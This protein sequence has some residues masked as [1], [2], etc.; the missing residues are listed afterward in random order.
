M[1]DFRPLTKFT[2]FRGRVAL[3]AILKAL[4]VGRGDRVGMQAYTCIAVPEAVLAAGA[5][6]VFIDIESEGL[7]MDASACTAAMSSGIKAIIVQHTFGLPADVRA[8][9]AVAGRHGIPVIEDC[10]HS[11]E[12][13]IAGRNVGSFGIAGFYSFEW[14]KPLVAGVGGSAVT[15]DVELEAKLARDYAGYISPPHTLDFRIRA[16]YL[17]YRLF[18]RPSF[19]WGTRRILGNFSNTGLVDSNYHKTYGE[20]E[21]VEF[22]YRMIESA[23]SRLERALAEI[24]AGTAHSNKI[25]ADYRR[26][27]GNPLIGHI[28]VPPWA[29]PVYA[30]YP[31]R[32]PDKCRLL[33]AAEKCRVEIAGWYATPVHPLLQS[34]W[35][36]VGYVAG[37]CPNAE[38]AC[39]EVVSL[40]T[41]RRVTQADAD[42]AVDFLN[43]FHL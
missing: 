21:S 20:G 37:S 11:L 2:Y 3:Y 4:G 5:R 33:G 15:T 43:T 8:I 22:K 32:S 14:G 41:H 16:Q 13:Q 7:N 28:P 9:Q 6:P 12:T 10:C 30:R 19:Y 35:K 39:S 1:T 34:E 23:K 17:A 18:F 38:R 24:P 27:I 36:G 42:K 29:S 31:L 40:P 25:V 26:G